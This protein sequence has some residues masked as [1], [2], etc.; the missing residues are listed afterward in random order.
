MADEAVFPRWYYSP[1]VPA[2]RVFESQQ[3]LDAAR[4]EGPWYTTPTE[5]ADAAAKATT[6]TEHQDATD[7]SPTRRSHR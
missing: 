7:E 5:A 3:A 4:S 2:G 6:V 1:Q